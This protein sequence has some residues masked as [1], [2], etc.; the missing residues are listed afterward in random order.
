[1]RFMEEVPLMKTAVGDISCKL[2]NLLEMLS[3]LRFMCKK[4]MNWGQNHGCTEIVSIQD[5]DFDI[6]NFS[7]NYL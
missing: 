1:M 5:F 3:W 7:I 6:F 2:L 4:K